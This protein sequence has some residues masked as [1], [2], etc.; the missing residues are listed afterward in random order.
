MNRKDKKTRDTRFAEFL[1]NRDKILP[2][3]K[4]YSPIEHAGSD[5]PPVFMSYTYPP[6]MGKDQKDPTHTADFGAGLKLKLDRLGV[7]CELVYPGSTN[8]QSHTM[9]VFL[10]KELTTPGGDKR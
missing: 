10:I 4:K 9:K 5:D 8:R 6:A 3:I 1:A 2:W 7:D